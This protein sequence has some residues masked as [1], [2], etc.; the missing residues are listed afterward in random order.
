MWR[1]AT[2]KHTHQ[3]ETNQSKFIIMFS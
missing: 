3:E 1:K 2:L